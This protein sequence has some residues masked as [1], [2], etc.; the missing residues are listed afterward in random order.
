M[1]LE[2]IGQ[3]PKSSNGYIRRK[4]EK[5]GATK[6]DYKIPSGKSNATSRLAGTGIVTDSKGVGYGSPSHDRLVYLTS[7]LIGQHVEVQVK[8]GSIY[9]GIFHATN[10]DK[11]YGIILRMA[12]LTKDGSLQGQRSGFSKAPS[13]TLIIPSNDLVQ[14]IAKDVSFFRDDQTSAPHYDMHHEIM[15]DSVISQSRHVETGRELQRWVP[16]EE[17]PEC[18]ELEN[19][20]DGPWNR[21]WDQFETNKMLFGVKSTF[22]EELYTTKLE[23]GPQTRELE[24]QALRIAREIEGEETQDLHLAEER[25]L[26]NNFDIDEETRFSSVY[27][28]N[29]A[30]DVGYDEDEDKLDSHSSERFDNIYGLVN[31]RPGEVSGQKGNN[32]AQT[33]PNF[34]SVD[35]SELPQSTTAMDLCRSGSNDHAKQL[36]SELPAQS[37]SFSDGEIRIQENSASNLHGATDNTAEENWIQA[38]D[39]QLSKSQDLKS[40][41][42]SKNK[43]SKEEG[44]SFNGPSCAPSTHI[45]LKTPEET[46]SVGGTKSVISRGRQGSSTSTSGP[47]LSP[48]SSVGSLSSEK[49]TLNPYAKEFKL[50]PNAKSFMPSQA[51][52]RPRSPVSDGSFYYPA[53][54][55]TVPNMPAMPMGIGVGTTFAGP[56]PVM[57]NPQVAQMPSQP[58]FHPNGPQYGQ[59]LGHPRQVLYVPSFQPEMPYK[60]RDY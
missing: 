15:V 16:D 20:F 23:K 40:S 50:N 9:S 10:T 31:K 42:E 44:L 33:W 54:V 24:K 25:G 55:S 13:K 41:L 38:E 47:G 46:V 6:S 53:T 43:S 8:N 3:Q 45:L 4:S 12:C 17:D 56:Q 52:A 32:G 26:Y 58:Y 2:Q 5:E 34:S 19:I 48:S 7:C 29:I 60:G 14:V 49:S 57:Y 51:H 11:D 18:P 30:D 59:L 27:R 22:N 35:H 21:G 37:C 1:N 36:A 28:G 39:V